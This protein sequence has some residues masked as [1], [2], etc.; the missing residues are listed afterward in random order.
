MAVYVDIL[1]NW[2]W[3]LGP[4]CHMIADSVEELKTFAV[5]IGLKESWLQEKKTGNHKDP[6]FDLTVGMRAK[7]VKA[8]AIELDDKHFVAK[9][10]E[11]RGFPQEKIDQLLGKEKTHAAA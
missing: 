8:G 4:S 7:A 11:H 2:G 1:R 9:L 3:K 10:W 5:G 6:H